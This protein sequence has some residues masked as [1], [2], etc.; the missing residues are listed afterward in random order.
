MNNKFI[1]NELLLGESNSN[2]LASL[3]VLVVGCGGVGGYAIESLVRLGVKNFTLVDN[4]NVD[5]SNFNRQIIAINSNL[6][7]SK[8]EA[9]KE[10]ILEINNEAKVDCK[11]LFYNKENESVIFD[12]DYDYVID[13][14]DTLS[15]KWELIKTCLEKKIKFISSMGMGNKLDLTKIE[16]TTLDKTYN[17]P[18]SKRLRSF[19]K[20][21]RID[22]KKIPVV[23]SS[24]LPYKQT[25]M[26]NKNG[27]TLKERI[28]PSSIIITP[29]VAGILIAQ[30]ILEK[31]INE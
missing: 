9:F 12:K 1:R 31:T 4:D 30:Y 5:L 19:S 28:P 2:K 6:N 26:I 10:R 25:L 23:F 3:S 18:V 21:D 11:Q 27:K 8:V 17:D 16:I 22:S 24:E 7:K 15:L 20:K 14:I 29:S 13:A